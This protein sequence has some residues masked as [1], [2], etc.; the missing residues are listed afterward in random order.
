MY[1]KYNDVFRFVP[2][3]GDTAG[4]CA[5]TDRVADSFFSPAG[6]NRGGMRNAIKL[7]YNPRKQKEIDYI[8]QELTQLLTFQAKV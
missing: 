2:L 4:L 7:S 6:F 3:N 5:N 1:D 8:V